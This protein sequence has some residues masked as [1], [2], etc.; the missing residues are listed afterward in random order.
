M[1]YIMAL[2]LFCTL[3]VDIYGQQQNWQNKDLSK[4]GV[5]GISTER[6]YQELLKGKNREIYYRCYKIDSG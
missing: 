6:A 3:C 1:K 4:D 2:S 5:F